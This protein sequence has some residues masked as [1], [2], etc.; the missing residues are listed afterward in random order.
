MC[1]VNII[2]NTKEDFYP[3]GNSLGF[4]TIS[5]LRSCHTSELHHLRFIIL[6]VP[7]TYKLVG[8]FPQLLCIYKHI[9]CFHNLPLLHRRTTCSINSHFLDIFYYIFHD[10]S[11]YNETRFKQ[12]FIISQLNVFSVTLACLSL[13]SF[14]KEIWYVFFCIV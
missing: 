9:L 10:L 14:M 12:K 8:L 4:N 11:A 3:Y 5:F 7:H 2:S 13:V 1:Q 6:A